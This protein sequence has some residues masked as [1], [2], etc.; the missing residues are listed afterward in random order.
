VAV[1]FH[2]FLNILHAMKF[3]RIDARC[4]ASS[5]DRFP[6]LS[7]KPVQVLAINQS[8]LGELAKAAANRLARALPWDRLQISGFAGT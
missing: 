5:A 3:R 8:K 4:F 1:N 6:T 2:D 7:Q